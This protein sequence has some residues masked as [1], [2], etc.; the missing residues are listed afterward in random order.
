[1]AGQYCVLATCALNQW[2]LD[3]EGNKNRIL[4]SIDTAKA[5]G[6]KYRVGPEL[7]ICGYGC[8]D[9]FY[10]MDT[11]VHSWEVLAEIIASKKTN[12]IV[13]D[14][15]M[16]I[17]HKNVRYNC[18]IFVLDGQILFIRPKMALADSGNYREGRW[19][20]PWV[21][22]RKL[23]NFTLPAIIRDLTGQV[24]VPIGD[25]VLEFLDTTLGCETCEELF[26]P[27]S[28]HIAMGLD[29]VEIFSNASGSHHQLRKL[30]RRIRLIA[31]GMERNGGVYL[32]SNHRGCDGER[33]Y[34]DGS[35]LV[36]INGKFVGQGDQ[37]GLREVVIN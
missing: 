27:D 6:A 21:H 7:E 12:G 32:Y 1:M 22:S 31:N 11:V 24:T 26:T 16:P 15:G 17:L 36:C 37:F 14:F 9:H 20:T 25:G 5:K 30:D 4:R 18:R 3:F 29:G 28:S 33:V 19:F 13:C 23:D 8:N 34:Y 35:P 2:A 10:E